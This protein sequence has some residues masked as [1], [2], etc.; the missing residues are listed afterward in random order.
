MPLLQGRDSRLSRKGARIQK[1][2]QTTQHFIDSYLYFLKQNYTA[3][4]KLFN[5]RPQMM[6]IVFFYVL[7]KQSILLYPKSC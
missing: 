6:T 2:A 1:L 7:Y 3:I 5:T 4:I